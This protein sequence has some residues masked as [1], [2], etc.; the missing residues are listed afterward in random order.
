MRFLRN[1]LIILSC[2]AIPVVGLL[3][4]ISILRE[5]E[6]AESSVVPERVWLP[7]E[8]QVLDSSQTL[9]L[10]LKWRDGAPVAAPAWEGTVTSVAIAPGDTVT[11]GT[12]VVQI[13]GIWR[14]AVASSIPLYTAVN[15]TSTSAEKTLGVD[16]LNRLGYSHVDQWDWDA[17]LAVRDLASNIGV[18]H[19]ELADTLDPAW[20]VWL[21]AESISVGAASVRAGQPAPTTGEPVFT[22]KP[23]LASVTADEQTTTLPEFDG[24]TAWTLAVDDAE[25]SL[26][27]LPLSDTPAL[28]KLSS[29]VDA[30][31]EEITATLAL[32]KAPTGWSVPTKAVVAQR[33]GKQ[34]VFV[35]GGKNASE[36]V[37]ITLL[38]GAPPGISWVS[39]KGYDPSILLLTNPGEFRSSRSCS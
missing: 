16:V 21:S 31:T 25:V 26:K 12:R 7:I 14:I 10:A 13:D 6:R 33:D 38:P 32:E 23:S 9:T 17:V 4:G 36:P 2:V 24:K 20:F 30:G 37:L 5:I 19:S 35:K 11:T 15:E 8:A 22:T 29:T 28:E 34:C 3:A 39:A 27:T 18:P 1:W